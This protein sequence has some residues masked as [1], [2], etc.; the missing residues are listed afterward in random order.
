MLRTV[1]W[2]TL[3]WAFLILTIP[4]LWVARHYDRKGNHEKHAQLT[5]RM[6]ACIARFLFR[7]TGSRVT[8]TGLE[9]VPQQGA[10]LF[11]GNHQGH[12]D[13][14]IIHGFIPKLKGFISIVEVL[15]FPIIRSWMRHM[16]C[17][18]LDRTDARQSAMCLVEAIGYLKQ[19]HSMVVFP[20]GRLSDGDQA[21][22][23]K[24]GWLR[25][26]T[27]SGVPIIP[28]SIKGSYQ[29]LA[30]DGS[31]VCAAS[32]DCIISEPMTTADLKK[33]DE[34]EFINRLQAVIMQQVENG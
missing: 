5:E 18:F 10:V 26:A 22:E 15:K 21:N 14:L 31:R 19:G 12:M 25:L 20:E 23:F 3:G 17:V 6:T 9:H 13:S 29:I 16:K 32:V 1:L 33:A 7:L 8:V 30:K 34:P 4:A 27:K 11:V 2:Y 28:V 24:R